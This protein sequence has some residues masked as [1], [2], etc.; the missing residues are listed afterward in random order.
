MSMGETKLQRVWRKFNLST[1]NI[2][3]SD[4]SEYWRKTNA[5]QLLKIMRFNDVTT[6]CIHPQYLFSTNLFR[7]KFD[8]W[9]FRRTEIGAS[10]SCSEVILAVN[11]MRTHIH[12]KKLLWSAEESM[13]HHEYHNTFNKINTKVISNWSQQLAQ[14][15]IVEIKKKKSISQKTATPGTWTVRQRKQILQ[16]DCRLE[17][18][19]TKYILSLNMKIWS[20]IGLACIVWLDYHWKEL[21]VCYFTTPL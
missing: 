3:I 17:W 19:E 1:G 5:V 21:Q 13:Q 11:R 4:F 9:E 15:Q 16:Q 7:I 6:A 2:I 12:K 18:A 8:Q 14:F 10:N 20:E